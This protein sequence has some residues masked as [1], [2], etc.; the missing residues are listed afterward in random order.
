MPS[1]PEDNS[2]VT[3]KFEDFEGT[4]KLTK[5]NNYNNNAYFDDVGSANNITDDY[6]L[7]LLSSG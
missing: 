7:L 3:R 5:Y 1:I 4:H 6:H 2:S